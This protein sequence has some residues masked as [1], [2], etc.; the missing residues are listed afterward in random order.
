MG[1]GLKWATCNVG[2]NAPE[3]YGDYF[4]WGETA[5]KSDYSWSTYFDNPSGDGET[6]TKYATDK[7]T[8][9]DLTDDAATQNWGSTWRIPTDAEWTTLRNTANF[10]WEWDD[11]RKGYTV[12]SKIV[13]YVG[14]TIFLPAAG[15][16]LGTY[17]LYDAGYGYYYGY[18]WSSTLYESLSYGARSVYFSSEIVKRYGEHRYYGYPVRPVSE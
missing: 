4:A 17:H 14:N 3:A 5:T 9:L 1:D 12:T 6:F 8:A 10:D 7:K 13:G 2:A 15:Y 11:T 16:R 18:Y